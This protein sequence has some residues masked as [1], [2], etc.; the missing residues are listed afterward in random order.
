MEELQMLR[1]LLTRVVFAGLVLASCQGCVIVV[2]AD[3]DHDVDWLSEHHHDGT[4]RLGIGIAH[5]DKAL[6]GQLNINADHATLVTS[7]NPGS[8]AE[9]A[10]VH[11]FDVIT[12][13]DGSDDASTG[14][15]WSA[16]RAKQPGE[17]I[18]LTVIRNAQ[19]MDLAVTLQG[20]TDDQVH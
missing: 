5:V 17:V 12:K 4:P 7:V 11:Q 8:P 14:A 16:V 19:P 18:T 3:E 20:P 10:G 15:L 6:A 13:V 9:R 2:D 1:C